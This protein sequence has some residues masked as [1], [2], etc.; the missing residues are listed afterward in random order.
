MTDML[1]RRKSGAKG[2]TDWGT[3]DRFRLREPSGYQIGRNLQ[4]NHGRHA[5]PQQVPIAAHV[6]SS[7]TREERED[8]I[9]AGKS[10]WQE[11]ASASNI[12]L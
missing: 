2:V 7:C 1:R 3:F 4:E 8:D 11:S 9:L 6:A 12:D 5:A 10:P